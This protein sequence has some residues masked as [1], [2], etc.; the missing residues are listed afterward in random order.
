MIFNNAIGHRAEYIDTRLQQMYVDGSIGAA[1]LIKKASEYHW[2]KRRESIDIATLNA[3]FSKVK[4]SYYSVKIEKRQICALL[5]NHMPTLY[6]YPEKWYPPSWGIEHFAEAYADRH[7]NNV[8]NSK[9]LKPLMDILAAKSIKKYISDKNKKFV[10]DVKELEEYFH[11]TDQ[12]LIQ[13]YKKQKKIIIFTIAISHE[14]ARYHD[15]SIGDFKVRLKSLMDVFSTSGEIID[16]PIESGV[17]IKK[18]INFAISL[19]QSAIPFKLW[20]IDKN[21]VKIYMKPHK[22]V[23]VLVDIAE[24]NIELS[25]KNEYL[26]VLINP[27]LAC[28]IC[29]FS[30]ELIK[31]FMLNTRSCF[32]LFFKIAVHS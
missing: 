30:L 21:Y 16:Y 11:Q 5:I 1:K 25:F 27:M 28:I 18:A 31:M 8:K 23:D 10:Q 3:Y 32:A 6:F 22:S 13:Y 2:S 12:D 9:I 14:H 15:I 4:I 7:F 29:K 19:W 17:L 24:S 26:K 20:S